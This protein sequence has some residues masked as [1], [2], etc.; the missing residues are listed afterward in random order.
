MWLKKGIWWLA[1]I[2]LRFVAF[3]KNPIAPARGVP[4]DK[5]NIAAYRKPKIGEC[6]IWDPALV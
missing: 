2:C 5:P 4:D 3:T 6:K 1:A